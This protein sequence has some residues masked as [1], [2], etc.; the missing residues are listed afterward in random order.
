MEVFLGTS[1]SEGLYHVKTSGWRKSL[2]E[3]VYEQTF[4]TYDSVVI[5][6]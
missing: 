3:D 6:L 2:L 4:I 1:F 5:K